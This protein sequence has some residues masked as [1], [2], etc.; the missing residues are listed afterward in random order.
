MSISQKPTTGPTIY[1][2]SHVPSHPKP[3]DSIWFCVMRNMLLIT[4]T[5]SFPLKM[6]QPRAT[7]Q[8]LAWLH[9]R[10]LAGILQLLA[11][12]YFS[13]FFLVLLLK[14]AGCTLWPSFRICYRPSLY[15]MGSCASSFSFLAKFTSLTDSQEGLG[16]PLSRVA[17]V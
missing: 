9:G 1:C 6:G 3:H 4:G 11:C 14:P 12:G 10:D 8:F 2:S 16:H 13:P 7:S 17:N 5:N 15:L